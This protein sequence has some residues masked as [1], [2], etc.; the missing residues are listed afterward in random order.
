MTCKD[1]LHHCKAECCREVPL[2]KALVEKHQDLLPRDTH[3]IYITDKGKYILRKP[4][5][6]CGFLDSETYTCKI[7]HERSELCKGY[8][9][10]QHILMTCIW[11]AADG[12]IRTRQARRNIKRMQIKAIVSIKKKQQ[13]LER[14]KNKHLKK[15]RRKNENINRN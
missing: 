13:E 15:R 5:G 14:W 9:D 11:M 10:E 6:Y 7:Y 3:C 1:I 2:P 4:D 8:G 12:S